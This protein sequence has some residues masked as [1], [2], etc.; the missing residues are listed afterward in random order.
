MI[1]GLLAVMLAV[2]ACEQPDESDTVIPAAISYTAVQTGGVDGASDSTGIE[3]T[4]SESVDHLKLTAA[5]ITMSGAAARGSAVLTGSG[6]TRTLAPIT[7]NEAGLATVVIAKNGVERAARNVIVHKA[8]QATPEY[9]SVIWHLDGGTPGA[10]EYPAFIVKGAVLARPF[11]DPVKTNNTFGGW[12]TNAALTQMYNFSGF[13]TADLN[14]Y[15]KWYVPIP[16]TG[17]MVQIPAGNFTM[18]SP[19]TE[20]DRSTTET[21]WQVTLSAFSMGKYEVTQA[22]YEEVMGTNPSGFTT[23]ADAG[24]TQNR[25]PVERVSWFDALVFCNRLSIAEGLTPAY[26]IDGKT[27]PDEWGAA[28][29]SSWGDIF[30]KWDAVEIVSDST[31]YRLP[32]EAQWEYACRAGTITAYY[33]GD[34]MSYDA[35]WYSGSSGNKTHEVGRKLPNMW[36]LYD[37]H[38]NV[39]EWC[40]DRNGNYPAG[41][42]TDPTGGSGNLRMRRGGS[43]GSTYQSVRCAYRGQVNTTLRDNNTG[44]RLVRP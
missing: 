33:V 24:E 25:R 27:N 10:G 22:Q 9:W 18:G 23:G 39:F 6:A 38:G 8:G 32:T 11:P 16:S 14:L 26:R 28:P 7:V 36:G 5:A 40:W 34:T 4:F 17:E 35:G 2:T 19:T 41:P 43:W 13:V 1:C 3:L 29:T 37:M 12:Y 15:A 30:D 31:G 44:L 42:A 20:A 21:Q